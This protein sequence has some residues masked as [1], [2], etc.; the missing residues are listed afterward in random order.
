M[1]PS[2]RLASISLK[3]GQRKAQVRRRDRRTRGIRPIVTLLEERTLLS[4]IPLT[5]NTL[6]D[7]PSG[8]I[9]GY[10]L[11]DAITQADAD[12]ANQYVI[13]FA[14]GLQGPID[15]T[16]ALP[17][18]ANNITIQG[19]GASNLTVQRDPNAAQ[20]SVFTVDSGVSVSVSGM[21][22]SGGNSA[23]YGGGIFNDGALTVTDCTF[24]SNSATYDGGGIYTYGAL[25]VTD[26]T[27]TNNS[28]TYYGGGIF[29]LSTTVSV[30]G[31]TFTSNSAPDGGG[32]G[33]A[34]YFYSTL[35]LTNS[36]FTSNSAPD[37]GGIYNYSMAT[38]TNCTVRGNTSQNA[39]GGIYN[40]GNLTLD[41]TIVANSPSG[42]DVA[43]LATLT[44]SHNLI[45]DGSGGLADTIVADPMLGPLADNGGP[46]QTM[47]LLP[48]SPAIDAG[49]AGAG[50]PATD[51]RG[52]L[53]GPAGLNA[54]TAVDIGAY[55]ASSSYLVTSTADSY[56]VGTLCAGV[57]WANVSTNANPANIAS[58]APNTVVFD[59]AGAFATP[60]TITLSPSLGT[61][62]PSNVSTA[63]TI[64]G[65]GATVLTVSG[66]GPSSNFAVFS[67][68]P[69]VTASISGLTIS[70][71]N[72]ID[73]G[74]VYNFGSL[75]LTD[76]TLSG[77]SAQ[78]YGGG[79]WNSGTA[80][81]TDDT[82]SGNSA[83]DDG[84][85]VFNASTAT[86][87]NDTLSG[88]LAQYGG[89]VWNSDTATLTND[90]LSGNSA[91]YGGGVYNNSTATLNNTVVAN[92][93]SG[94]D[95]SGSVI[96]SNNLIKD[97]TGGL[98]PTTNLLGVD[99]MLAPLGDY[100]GPT[101]TMPLLPGSPAIGAG[102][103]ALIPT[104]ITTD[105]RGE[106][107]IV[108]GSVDIGAF[109]SQ[110]FTL[111]PV[112]GSTPQGTP[113]NSPFA[114]PLAVIVTAN[115][116]LE[117][118][119]GGIVIFSAPASGASASLSLSSPVTIGS[120]G[121]ASV[122]AT[123]NAIGGQY[124]VSASTAAPPPGRLHVDQHR[125]AGPLRPRRPH[126]RLRHL[127]RHPLR[128][129]PGRLDRTAGQ[130]FDHTRRRHP[131]GRHRHLRQLLGGLQH[132]QPGRGRFALHHLLRLR[133]QRRLPRGHRHQ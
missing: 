103:T 131:I 52:A 1:W 107:R 49:I 46:T 10:T 4:Q 51:Q 40:V 122:T 124:T 9:S 102:S 90:T 83:Q 43:N 28:G 68:N 31:S 80:T 118:V 37:G 116:P 99:P 109:E 70:N 65:T 54:G 35:T 76:D 56:D 50:I 16:Q 45:E 66:G 41:N 38:V 14:S 115:N 78:D 108:N 127:H 73:G 120:N 26:S 113:V 15:L 96:G 119:A 128:H 130:R 91:Q 81:L 36:T 20:F 111:T 7:D 98:D 88:N 71:G 25:T 12:T 42:S 84:G 82:L 79:V 105:Q 8:P 86:L 93:P 85:G 19:P 126:D 24:T 100:G 72:A 18:L 74:G 129:H 34:N 64:T 94:G 48:G 3:S 89:G 6:A 112:T 121:Q 114:N 21:T 77:N 2:Q 32:G 5:V 123:A 39:G 29:T 61:L 55:E 132:R 92:S 30:S 47:A 117:P 13:N 44:G 27:F 110:G 101:Q 104:G 11:R 53:R 63:E 23:S 59:T 57:G 22:I 69:G 87:T 58:P 106:P 133:G 67:V 33:I 125:P 17:D 75:T 95:I 97:G 62:E 60:Q